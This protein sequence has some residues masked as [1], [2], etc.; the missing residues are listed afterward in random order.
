MK[1]FTHLPAK[2]K[3]S[4]SDPVF[5]YDQL[6]NWCNFYFGSDLSKMSVHDVVIAF[7]DCFGGFCRSEYY[8]L[9]E[10]LDSLGVCR[11]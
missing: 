3:D 11:W 4:F 9:C 8:S 1:S 5:S 7:C 10:Y 6:K 2:Y